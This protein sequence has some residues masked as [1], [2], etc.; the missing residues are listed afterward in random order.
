MVIRHWVQNIPQ[1]QSSRGLTHKPCLY[2][3]GHECNLQ[4]RDEVKQ[5]KNQ[6]SAHKN[7]ITGW[8]WYKKIL[9]FSNSGVLI[10]TNRNPLRSATT[11]VHSE[12]LNAWQF[13][14]SIPPTALLAPWRTKNNKQVPLPD[15]SM[16]PL[17][18]MDGGSIFRLGLITRS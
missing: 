18:Q 12:S 3:K 16:G 11:K 6:R 13:P 1:R 5:V 9:R 15:S 2:L 7:F 10:L 8:K 14:A 4:T 17:H